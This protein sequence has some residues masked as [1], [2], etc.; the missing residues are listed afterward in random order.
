MAS[1]SCFELYNLATDIGETHD[2]SAQYPDRVR[3]LSKLIEGF[4]ADT[5]AVVPKPNPAYR[6]DASATRP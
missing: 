5:H 2:I 3:E 4:L 1:A 6:A